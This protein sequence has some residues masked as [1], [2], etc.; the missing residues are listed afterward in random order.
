[1]GTPKQTSFKIGSS[2]L[3]R[4]KVAKVRKLKQVKRVNIGKFKT[5][6]LKLSAVKR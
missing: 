2:K 3:K 1:M 4:R 6:K 5:K